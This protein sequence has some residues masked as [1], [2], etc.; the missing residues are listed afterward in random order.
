[1]ASLAVVPSQAEPGQRWLRRWYPQRAEVESPGSP[2]SAGSRCRV[3]GCSS[4][5]GAALAP[6]CAQ[7]WILRNNSTKE[8]FGSLQLSS[9]V[10]WGQ[11]F[12]KSLSSRFN[13]KQVI[14]FLK[15][16]QRF[17]KMG[18]L[19]RRMLSETDCPSKP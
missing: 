11:F 2:A 6:G 16:F 19:S 10:L 14:P 17:S 18:K 8:L 4:C 13:E 5:V 9:D 12:P 7:H 3:S 1:M 15:E